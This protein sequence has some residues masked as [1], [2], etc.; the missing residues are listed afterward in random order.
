MKKI[1]EHELNIPPDYQY[2]A[3]RSGGLFQRQWH[4]NRLKLIESIGFFKKDDCAADIGCGSGN[5]ILEFSGKVGS[6]VAFDYN[7]ESLDFLRKKLK[8]DGIG[9][10]EVSEFDLLGSDFNE[11]QGRFDKIVLNE[12]IE[13]FEWDDAVEVMRNLKKM[14]KEGGE[15]LITT[16]NYRSLWPVMEFLADKTNAFPTLWGEQHKIKFTK[17]LL[18]G[19]CEDN[20]YEII[21]VGT[22]GL[23]SPFLV[24]FGKKIADWMFGI[25]LRHIRFFGPQLFIRAKK[26]EK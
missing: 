20:G 21:D 8:E 5:V 6:F 12:V 25:E 17:K 1:V 3:L 4:R 24:I 19:I 7:D 15:I 16:P 18:K 11:F 22:F 13:H 26:N 23:V 14:L 2:N 10:V 9:N